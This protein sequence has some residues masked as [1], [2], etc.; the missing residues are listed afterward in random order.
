MNKVILCGNLG[1]DPEIRTTNGG[2]SVATLRL[3]TNERLKTAAGDWEPH[4]EWHRVTAWGKTAENLAQYKKKGDTILVEGRLQT[5]KWQ[6]D[7]GADRYSTEVV[8]DKV[9]FVGGG[10][11][12]GGGSRSGAG[13][14]GGGYGGGAPA[15][16][17]Y[18]AGGAHR[19]THDPG[20]YGGA[21][22]TG[23]APDGYGGTPDE[24]IPF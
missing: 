17:G 4:T 1:A 15:G 18:G 10:R 14:S 24:D 20:G 9:E 5:R 8:A 12:E 22:G 21:S 23:H 16:G 7:S 6:D 3:A 19:G 13:G 11:S 2:T